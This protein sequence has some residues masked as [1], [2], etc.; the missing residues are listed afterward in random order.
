MHN[1]EQL[2]APLLLAA[3]ITNDPIPMMRANILLIFR[4]MDNGNLNPAI[5][6]VFLRMTFSRINDNRLMEVER[7]SSD[8]S[9]ISHGF[10]SR[11]IRP[12]PN[13]DILEITVYQPGS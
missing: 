2:G 5:V 13:G 3:D 8:S 12:E 11:M 7:V 4:S 9:V 1:Y 10:F 6:L